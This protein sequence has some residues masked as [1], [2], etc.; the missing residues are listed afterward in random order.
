MRCGNIVKN[1]LVFARGSTPN[2]QKCVLSEVIGRA[3]KIVNHHTEL[4]HIKVKKN[5]NIQPGTVICDPDQ[6]LQAFVALLINA[7][8]AM[9]NGGLLE[10]A[11]QNPRD[12]DN[13]VIVTIRDTGVGIPDDVKDKILEPFFTTK[14]EKNGVG[15]GLSVVYGIIQHHKGKIWLESQKGEG[16]TFYIKLPVMQQNTDIKETNSGSSFPI[17]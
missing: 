5:I 12:D 16:T 1:L 9:P 7:V 3:L 8:E 15:L 10:V 2:F 17:S 11:V 6:L 14:K 13:W 4:A